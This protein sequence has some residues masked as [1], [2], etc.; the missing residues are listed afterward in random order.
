LATTGLQADLDAALQYIDA[1]AVNRHFRA[2]RAG[3]PPNSPHLATIAGL[4]KTF[5]IPGN[6]D[7]Y[8]NN[9]GN[10]GGVLFDQT[11][12][13]YWA[14]NTH[15]VIASIL[16]KPVPG[17]S[18]NEVEHLAL[19][20]VDACL[21]LNAHASGALGHLGQGYVYANTLAELQAKTKFARTQYPDIAVIWVV[22]FPPRLVKSTEQL[23]RYNLIEQASNSLR[24]NL[25][26][27]GHTHE[28]YVYPAGIGTA[29]WNGGSAT[30]FAESRGNWIQCLDVEVL[31]DRFV[32][33]TR[34]NYSWD[35]NMGDFQKTG[36]DEHL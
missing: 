3:E 7:R 6:H 35:T 28:N 22:H 16:E 26:L 27:S 15:G 25:I 29:V 10:A 34:R 32:A 18:F 17:S 21:Q 31:N 33:A 12:A 30:Q 23:L 9:K 36:P 20:G 24:V 5:L 14:R 2:P 1:P 19:I 4:A 11:F 8:Q 13:S